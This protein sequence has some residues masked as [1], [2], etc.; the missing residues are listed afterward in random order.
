MPRRFRIQARTASIVPVAR[1]TATAPPMMKQKKDD[2]LTIRES[3]WN[4]CQCKPRGDG[5]GVRQD[6]IGA[7]LYDLVPVGICNPFKLALRQQVRAQPRKHDHAK[8]QNERVR[9]SQSFEERRFRVHGGPQDWSQGRVLASP[10]NV[11]T[12]RWLRTRKPVCRCRMIEGTS[13]L[14]VHGPP[15][16]SL[17]KALSAS[18]G[19]KALPRFDAAQSNAGAPSAK[20][21]SMSGSDWQ[22]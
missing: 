7:S 10:A 17:A 5:L 19:A 6:V 9:D 14:S 3:T 21:T 12:R 13:T 20:V 15:M 11:S 16:D 18:S 4:G 2:R 1:M 8:Q 22:F